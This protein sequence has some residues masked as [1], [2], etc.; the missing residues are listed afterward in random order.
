MAPTPASRISPVA[1]LWVGQ[2]ASPLFCKRC[3]REN[4]AD[5]RATDTG[6]HLPPAGD[7]G[8]PST[9]DIALDRRPVKRKPN[10]DAAQRHRNGDGAVLP[11][12]A[13]GE[14]SGERA[15]DAEAARD[16]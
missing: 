12:A 8:A 1:T 5:V 3:A 10:H 7:Q 9:G 4:H 2:P 6:S 13:A 14:W 16:E 15:Q 11:L